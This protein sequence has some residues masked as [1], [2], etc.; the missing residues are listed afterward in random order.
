MTLQW[1]AYH[2]LWDFLILP[3]WCHWLFYLIPVP[4]NYELTK[5]RALFFVWQSYLATLAKCSISFCKNTGICNENMHQVKWKNW[6]FDIKIPEWLMMKRV[7]QTS[8][9]GIFHFGTFKMWHSIPL[10]CH[11]L[12]VSNISS[13]E[14]KHTKKEFH[15]IFRIQ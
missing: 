12:I 6:E 11:G 9:A 5:P 8:K 3:F 1:A 7:R 2:H 14:K 4:M 10:T 15:S 13:D